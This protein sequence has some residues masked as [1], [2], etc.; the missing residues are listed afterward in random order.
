MR[1]TAI[2]CAVAIVMLTA[3]AAAH[4]GGYIAID[5]W[6]ASGT[7]YGQF[8]QP[9]GIAIDRR[10][11]VSMSDNAKDQAGNAAYCR[12]LLSVR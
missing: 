6:G 5:S 9:K 4:A 2:S 3:T 10:G 8:R 12:G 7:G 1:K 11:Y